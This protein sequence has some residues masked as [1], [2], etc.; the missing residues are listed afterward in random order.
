MPLS[1][2]FVSGDP[3]FSA[4][5]ATLSGDFEVY[6]TVFD[7]GAV[8]QLTLRLGD[9]TFYSGVAPDGALDGPRIGPGPSGALTGSL[10]IVTRS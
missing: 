1:V 5:T 3:S 4:P 2:T 7:S 9:Y 8:S 6:A 10:T